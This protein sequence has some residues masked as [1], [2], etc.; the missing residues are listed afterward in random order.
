M[1]I[2]GQQVIASCAAIISLIMAV[3]AAVKVPQRVI[4]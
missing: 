3:H 1:F 2:D 4:E